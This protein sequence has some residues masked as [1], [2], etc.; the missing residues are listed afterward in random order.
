MQRSETSFDNMPMSAF[1]VPIMF[2]SVGRC[3]EMGDTMGREKNRRAK[4]S[5]PLF[6]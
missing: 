6:V 3:S 2:R 1:R 4:N 5:P